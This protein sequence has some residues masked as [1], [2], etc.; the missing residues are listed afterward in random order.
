MTDKSNNKYIDAIL[1]D[2]DS[3]DDSIKKI[4]DDSI[5]KKI[6]DEI[7]FQKDI[8]NIDFTIMNLEKKD[9]ENIDFTEIGSDYIIK[10]IENTRD[11]IKG[12]YQYKYQNAMIKYGD[13]FETIKIDIENLYDKLITTHINENLFS[14]R[15]FIWYFKVPKYNN[16]NLKIGLLGN[17]YTIDEIVCAI[18]DEISQYTSNVN[19]SDSDRDSN[20]YTK[21]DKDIE[22]INEKITE[23][24]KLKN[25][26]Y[27]YLDLDKY[28]DSMNTRL[29]ALVEY[30]KLLPYLIKI[31]TGKLQT[32]KANKSNI[33]INLNRLNHISKHDIDKLIE[34]TEDI[35]KKIKSSN[36]NEDKYNI[37]KDEFSEY[38]EKII[39]KIINIF[40][41]ENN[42][43]NNEIS[44]A[45]DTYL[46]S[47]NNLSKLS[48]VISNFKRIGTL[49]SS[50]INGYKNNYLKNIN[51]TEKYINIDN[52]KC[53]NNSN[54]NL[55]STVKKII[56][57]YNSDKYMFLDDDGITYKPEIV[58]LNGK[59]PT[60]LEYYIM[61][62]LKDSYDNTKNNDTTKTYNLD[63]VDYKQ[64]YNQK[65][66]IDMRN[67][68]R[69]KLGTIKSLPIKIKNA[70]KNTNIRGLLDRIRYDASQ[71]FK[72]GNKTRKQ[73]RNG[74]KVKNTRKKKYKKKRTRR[75]RKK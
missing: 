49:I 28:E 67:N 52:Y 62:I 56:N 63:Y 39:E 41:K 15:K 48:N 75:V 29:N 45:I 71:G 74:K 16:K 70:I 55:K 7:N 69:K 72:G 47:P 46:E 17:N 51:N 53:T 8:E 11:K 1:S 32:E 36:N 58:K 43:K 61:S 40:A 19:P 3:D 31:F 73:K 20:I 6:Y 26:L 25:D 60:A 34:R 57:Y 44:P 10:K 38:Y 18:K 35:K 64:K 37:M 54:V 66:L 23:L 65:D 27:N 21:I 59:I 14:S 33:K 50:K 13:E 22:N 2:D 42:W 12:E 24:E 4:Y 30:K 9:I 68:A 5:I